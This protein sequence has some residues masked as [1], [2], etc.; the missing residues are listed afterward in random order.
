MNPALLRISSNEATVF[1]FADED[2][3]IPFPEE[4]SP[5]EDAALLKRLRN[6]LEKRYIRREIDSYGLVRFYLTE[7]GKRLKM[8]L[9]D[10][11]LD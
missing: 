5:D 2:G 7:K 4:R 1:L 6:L 10:I 9:E 3:F 8:K 11:P